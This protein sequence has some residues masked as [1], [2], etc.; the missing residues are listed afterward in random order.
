M[1]LHHILYKNVSFGKGC[2]IGEKKSFRYKN[3]AM[4]GIT[5]KVH[6]VE[7]STQLYETE[8][9]T[10]IQS[11]YSQKILA[12]SIDDKAF[13]QGTKYTTGLNQF[14]CML[15]TA[16]SDHKPI[17]I[18]PDVLWLLICQGFA[19]HVKKNAWHLKWR[20]VTFLLGKKKLTVDMDSMETWNEVVSDVCDQISSYTRENLRSKLVLDFSTTSLKEKTAFE[21]AFMDAVSR[22]FDYEGISICGFPNIKLKGTIEDYQKMLTS[23]DFIAQYGLKWWVKPLKEVIQEIIATLDGKINAVFWERIFVYDPV[24]TCGGK[25]Q[26]T[27]WISYFFPYVKNTSKYSIRKGLVKNPHLFKKQNVV[28]GIEDFPSGLSTVDFKWIRST[29]IKELNLVSGFM[30]IKEN[31]EDG[32]LETE[33]NWYVEEK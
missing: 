23:L 18:T 27:G 29:E 15:L 28:L 32:F 1:S 13:I 4:E 3:T 30:G 17:V 26:L 9:G 11:Y 2:I 10:D 5:F 25:N 31:P 16:Y 21:I 24:I 7:Q 33:I 20:L 6:D 14:L 19:A 22:F 12:S 8:K